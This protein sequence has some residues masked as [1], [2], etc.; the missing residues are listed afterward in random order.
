MFSRY[1][2]IGT[3]STMY[4]SFVYMSAVCYAKDLE[5]EYKHNG[6]ADA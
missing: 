3:F 1:V 4:C 2:K 6:I 5:V